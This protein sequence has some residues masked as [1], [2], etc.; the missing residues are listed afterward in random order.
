MQFMYPGLYGQHDAAFVGW[1]MAAIDIGVTLSQSTADLFRIIHDLAQ[2]CMWAY[3]FAGAVIA[4]DRPASINRDELGRLHNEVG[5]AIEFRDGWKIHA[6]HGV[7]VPAWVIE[8][9]A[10]ITIAAIY[11][12]QNTEIQRVMIERFGWDRYAEESGAKI[13]DHDDRWGTLFVRGL[14]R[15]RSIAFLRVIN[16]SPE[17]DGTFR[18]YVLPVHPQLCPLPDG[19]D[20]NFGPPQKL[21]ALN[22]VASTF[23]MLGRDYANLMGA[24][25]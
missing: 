15:G 20:Q 11:A 18:K 12:E 13:V 23:G 2:S 8:E 21:T 25:S 5:A 4:C 24:E 14:R 7:R 9:P 22:A 16:R 1:T 19:P 6:V 17:P 3:T 10:R